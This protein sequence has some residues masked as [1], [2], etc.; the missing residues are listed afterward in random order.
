MAQQNI[1]PESNSSQT[2]LVGL[3]KQMLDQNTAVEDQIKLERDLADNAWITFGLNL[4]LR[5]K[6]PVE[7][8]AVK[9]WL[10]LLA[11]DFLGQ[12]PS[13]KD[14]DSATDYLR[15][16]CRMI[17]TQMTIDIELELICKTMPFV[18]SVVELCHGSA[19]SCLR[20]YTP[21]ELYDALNEIVRKG[22]LSVNPACFPTGP[23]MVTRMLSKHRAL[24]IKL[25]IDFSLRTSNG[26]KIRLQ[27]TTGSS[28]PKFLA[29]E[30][31]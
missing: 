8:P 31:A 2:D 21:S 30:P 9:D 26:M 15:A 7:H 16:R 1:Q 4:P 19:H 10:F 23:H 22:R 28:S 20:D 18:I 25:G 14:L 3:V 17:P 6:Y 13:R 11:T 24:L 12:A 29:L 5:G 27:T